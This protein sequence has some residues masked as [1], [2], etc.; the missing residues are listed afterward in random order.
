MVAAAAYEKVA[1]RMI[2]AFEERVSL[3][4]RCMF[5]GTPMFTAVTRV[6]APL[7]CVS[8]SCCIL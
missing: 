4:A 3:S 6:R 1:R 2:K 8:C 7:A 5:V